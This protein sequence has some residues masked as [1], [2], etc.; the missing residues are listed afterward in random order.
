MSKIVSVLI[1]LLLA[2]NNL[3]AINPERTYQYT[4]SQYGLRYKTLSVDTEDGATLS[5]WHIPAKRH[6]KRATPIIIANSDAGNMGYWSNLA[7]YLNYLDYD[8]W[9]FD[10]RGFGESSDFETKRE[11]LFYT[12]YV[13]DLKAVVGR[14]YQNR[15]QSVVLIGYSMGT[16]VIE[17]YLK[18]YP[19]SNISVAI[20]DGYVGNPHSFVSNMTKQGKQI[21]LPEGYEFNDT[22]ID[23]PTL[24]VSAKT[25]SNCP[26]ENIPSL[27]EKIKVVEY[28][29]G[30]IMALSTFPD[31]YITDIHTFIQGEDK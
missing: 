21:E 30:H 23:I 24:V 1:A 12:E 6:A 14:V 31:E 11:R 18:Q 26:K 3:L 8:V 5:V 20:L 25:D 28:D 29:C 15:K 4:P 7:Y 2:C 10:W 27:N 13:K 17:E 22:P 9:M 19:H 16:L